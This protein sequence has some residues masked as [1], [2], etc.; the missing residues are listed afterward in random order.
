MALPQNIQVAL[1]DM[2]MMYG[3]EADRS[4]IDTFAEDND[5]DSDVLWKAYRAGAQKLKPYIG[6]VVDAISEEGV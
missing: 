2:L 4:D 5:Y 1:T 3:T 6:Q